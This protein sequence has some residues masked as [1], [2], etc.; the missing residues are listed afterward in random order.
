[1]MLVKIKNGNRNTELNL[2]CRES[3]MQSALNAIW[4]EADFHSL[5]FVEKVI[6]PVDLWML[7]DRYLN[8]DELNFLTKRMERFSPDELLKFYAVVCNNGMDDLVEMINLSFNLQAYTL[9]RDVSSMEAI[10][11]THFLTIKNTL[12]SEGMEKED[13]EVVGKKLLKEGNPI[14]TI[15]GLLCKNDVEYDEVYDGQVFPCYEY[16]ENGLLKICL[17]I[18]GKTEYVFLP[19]EKM[20]IKKALRRLGASCLEDCTMNIMEIRVTN[21]G[22]SG[23]LKA[24]YR[25]KGL[26][27]LNEV[28]QAI[29]SSNV[30]LDKMGAVMEYAEVNTAIDIVQIIK[31]IN[32]FCID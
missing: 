7:G 4:L 32:N 2:P 9:I 5:V 17:E 8:L 29:S 16:R 13:F 25:R 28:A 10:G 12:S 27:E 19:E 26:Y 21:E 6:M 15:Y 18:N 30:D 1:M 22:W 3:E 31:N 23:Y 24:L 20:A 14:P 11:K